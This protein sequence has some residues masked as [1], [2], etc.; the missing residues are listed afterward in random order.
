MVASLAHAPM[1]SCS[2]FLVLLP[3]FFVCSSKTNPVFSL[4]NSTAQTDRGKGVLSVYGLGPELHSD[5][6]EY[7]ENNID[8]ANSSSPFVKVKSLYMYCTVDED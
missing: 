6:D 4:P 5:N 2:T 3:V 8:L 1:N 7:V